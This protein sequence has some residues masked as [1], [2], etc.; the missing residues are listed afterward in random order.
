MNVL[1]A[2]YFYEDKL[3]GNE[4][5]V[6]VNILPDSSESLKWLQIGN[7]GTYYR[8]GADEDR[9]N[10][11]EWFFRLGKDYSFGTDVGLDFGFPGLGLEADGGVNLSLN[12]NLEFGFGVSE[13]GGFYFIFGEEIIG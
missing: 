2:D 12:W 3:K 1:F 8:S 11:A 10:F 13:N 6:D 7:Q 4:T 5:K 9:G